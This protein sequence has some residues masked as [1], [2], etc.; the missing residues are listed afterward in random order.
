MRPIVNIALAGIA[1]Y[2]DA[3]LEAILPKQESVGARLVGVVDPLPQRCK[4]IG[5]LD[6][7]KVPI[8]ATMQALFAQSSV[9]LMLIV[10]PIHLHA[11]QTCFALQRGANVLCEKPIAG[12]LRDALR[13]AETQATSKQFAAIGYQWSFSQAVQSLKRDII[14]G[15]LGRPIRMKSIALHPRPMAYFRRNDWAGRLY[16]DDG[17]GI[18]DSPANNATAHFLHNMFYL[19]G[20][21]R[22]TS[23]APATVQA[24]LYRANDIEN[25]DTAAIRCVT[26]CGTEVL[27]Y[28][29][30]AVAER[31]G[32]RSRFEFE[33]GH[34]DFDTG[35]SGEFVARFNDGRVKYYGHPNFDRHEKIWQSID[36]VRTG[37][38][39]ACGIAA[40]MS[41]A[42][43]VA[44]AQ[45]SAGEVSEFPSRLRRVVGFDGDAMVS[46]DRL[47][48]QLIECYEREIMPAEHSELVWSRPGNVIDLK[49]R[50]GDA[51]PQSQPQVA[52]AV[53][54]AIATAAAAIARPLPSAKLL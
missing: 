50:N 9:D 6:R 22:E 21:T 48:E 36:A 7:L 39:V 53:H 2:G 8:H 46:I 45:E 10:T 25:F 5:D 18:F 29:S 37:K 35:G 30:H 32:P 11:A 24:E 33:L 19:L 40:A 27:F 1:G 4:R 3:Y 31:R 15:V 23:A 43:C 41:H 34:V 17:G 52:V 38:P 16:S 51:R 20:R 44:A 13:M 12:T 42:I 49:H 26:E 14:D 54:P 47:G 28:T